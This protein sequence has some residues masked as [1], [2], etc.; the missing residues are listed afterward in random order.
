MRWA[1]MTNDSP[2]A[3]KCECQPPG[4]SITAASASATAR[5][6]GSTEWSR[7]CFGVCALCDADEVADETG[8]QGGHQI[9]EVAICDAQ[10]DAKAVRLKFGE[11]AIPREGPA[12]LGG[13]TLNG[14]PQR[15]AE[16]WARDLL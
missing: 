8:R 9:E 12:P 6:S 14:K 7:L 15:P 16:E 11:E 10:A 4:S 13:P 5:Q 3:L 2:L 1:Q